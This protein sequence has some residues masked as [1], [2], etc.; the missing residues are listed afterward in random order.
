MDENIGEIHCNLDQIMQLYHWRVV[1]IMNKTGIKRNTCVKLRY[2]RN[3]GS[4]KLGTLLK[5]CQGLNCSLSE[6]IEYK[7]I[8]EII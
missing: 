2:D 5:V 6:L 4:V 3:L 8:K 7:P 1:D